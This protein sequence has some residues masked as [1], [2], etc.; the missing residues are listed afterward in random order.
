[1]ALLG[2]VLGVGA[3][4]AVALVSRVLTTVGDLLAAGLAAGYVRWSRNAV[5][6]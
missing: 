6:R 1:V 5:R 2:P 3:A 4:T